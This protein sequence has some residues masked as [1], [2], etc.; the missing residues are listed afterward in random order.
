M[1]QAVTKLLVLVCVLALVGCKGGSDSAKDMEKSEPNVSES[2]VP[3]PEVPKPNEPP[4]SEMPTAPPADSFEI[5]GTVV[6]KNLEGGFFAIDG[7]DGSK[8]DPI[9]LP[10][11][12]RKDGMKVKVT[13]RRRKDARSIHMYGAVI[14]VVDIAGR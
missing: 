14:E 11:S 6:Y 5:R 2:N 3:A 10:G 8:Y 13:A 4:S 7:D 1:K 9:N 12:F